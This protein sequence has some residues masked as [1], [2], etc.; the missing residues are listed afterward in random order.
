MGCKKVIFDILSGLN[1][2]YESP[3][4][5][6]NLEYECLTKLYQLGSECSE[7]LMQTGQELLERCEESED[8]EYKFQL[9]L[10]SLAKR[11][12]P[13]ALELNIAALV[14]EKTR[15][16]EAYINLLATFKN[17]LA[18]SALVHAIKADDSTGEEEGGIRYKAIEL[19]HLLGAKEVTSMIIPFVK[20]SAYRVRE[21]AIDFLVK[22]DIREVAPIFV[23]QLAQEEYPIN[24]AKL[25]S[26]LVSWKWTDTLP[27]LRELLA[28]DWVRNDKTL[29]TTVSNAILALS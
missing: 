7:T 28:S 4:K 16:K 3:T 12:H 2:E 14:S 20:D 15:D 17:P 29:Q 25:I 19:L 21:S 11:C 6:G 26:G 24:L 13:G 18:I 5:I 23:D 8:I 9:V 22:F 27:E 1:V 10:D